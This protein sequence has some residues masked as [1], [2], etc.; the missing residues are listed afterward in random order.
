VWEQPTLTSGLP[1]TEVVGTGIT[2]RTH[3]SVSGGGGAIWQIPV[4][5]SLGISNQG[6][7]LSTGMNEGPQTISGPVVFT[8]IAG[9]SSSTQMVTQVCNDTPNVP[10]SMT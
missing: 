1:A 7:A 10:K 3:T 4:V 9:P 6:R 2:S 8:P 5:S